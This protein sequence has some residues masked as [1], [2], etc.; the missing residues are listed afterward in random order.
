MGMQLPPQPG[1]NGL[2]PSVVPPQLSGQPGHMAFQLGSNVNNP[3]SMAS[4]PAGIPLSSPISTSTGGIPSSHWKPAQNFSPMAAGIYNL[5]R[6]NSAAAAQAAHLAL[7]A[8]MPTVTSNGNPA[9]ASSS[10]LTHGISAG[11]LQQQATEHAGGAHSQKPSVG[12]TAIARAVPASQQITPSQRQQSQLQQHGIVQSP[13]MTNSIGAA[14][15]R[16]PAAASSGVAPAPASAMAGGS[17]S[18]ANLALQTN[19]PSQPVSGSVLLYNGVQHR[20]THQPGIVVTQG[21]PAPV[22][23]STP[24]VPAAGSVPSSVAGTSSISAVPKSPH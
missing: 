14:Q 5:S 6:S 16:A 15:V 17:P 10:I 11:G 3:L 20:Q 9:V 12:P 8:G 4:P 23:T 19:M 24:P 1:K 13:Q 21:L 2:Q 22:T 7:S 18:R